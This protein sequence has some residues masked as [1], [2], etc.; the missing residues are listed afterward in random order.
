VRGERF[1][2]L[3]LVAFEME[4]GVHHDRR[5]AGSRAHLLPELV[6]DAIRGGD[7]ASLDPCPVEVTVDELTRLR[8]LGGNDASTNRRSRSALAYSRAQ[9]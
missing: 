2:E 5:V 4:R 3:E 9:T 6:H 8:A 7:R 1:Q